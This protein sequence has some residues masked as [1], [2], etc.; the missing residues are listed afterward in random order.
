MDYRSDYEGPGEGRGQ[1]KSEYRS[2]TEGE[3]TA[4]QVLEVVIYLLNL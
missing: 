3:M 2:T 1:R 4:V